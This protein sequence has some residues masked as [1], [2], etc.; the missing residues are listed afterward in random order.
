M[1]CQ[2]PDQGQILFHGPVAFDDHPPRRRL[3]DDT[4]KLPRLTETRDELAATVKA[5]GAAPSSALFM[6][7]LAT[8]PEVME[9]NHSRLNGIRVAAFAIHDLIV[10]ETKG[11]I[12][13]AL[14]PRP[15]NGPK[16][17]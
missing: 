10:S 5:L 16:R 9:R 13:P 1:V 12:I 11:P 3:V 4:G 15:P 2:F 8:K 17:D 7:E 14:E 6:G